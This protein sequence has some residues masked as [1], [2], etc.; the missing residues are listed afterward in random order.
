MY[1][2]ICELAW[3]RLLTTKKSFI[4]TYHLIPGWKNRTGKQL[5]N[6]EDNGSP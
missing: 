1:Y 6:G 2:I 3:Y 5:S 4:T